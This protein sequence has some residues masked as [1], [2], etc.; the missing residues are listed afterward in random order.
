MRRVFG[1]GE[2]CIFE[3]TFVAGGCFEEVLLLHFFFER[4]NKIKH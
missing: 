3:V 1:S 4:L 2:C